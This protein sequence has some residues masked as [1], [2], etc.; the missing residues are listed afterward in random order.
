MSCLFSLFLPFMAAPPAPET[1][2]TLAVHHDLA[3]TLRTYR[4]W[5]GCHKYTIILRVRVC[6]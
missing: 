3:F 6:Q 4:L 5:F 1:Q 2:V